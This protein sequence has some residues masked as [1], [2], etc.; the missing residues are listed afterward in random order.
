MF[1]LSISLLLFSLSPRIDGFRPTNSERN[2]VISA[3]TSILKP[4]NEMALLAKITPN[5]GESMDNYRK[6]VLNVLKEEQIDKS[7]V[8]LGGRELLDMIIRKWGVAYDIQLRKNKPFGDGS[9]NIYI[10]VMWRYFGQKSFPMD[11]REYLEHL[12]AI[13]RYITSVDKVQDFKE[14]VSD[15]RKRPNAYFGY[16]VGIALDVNP[17]TA[18]A[19][20]KDLPYE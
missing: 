5:Q 19:F 15:S 1:F 4:R 2:S 6:A 7:G 3:S 20:F 16:A 12:E 11:E 17:D 10:N 8:K 9:A 14:K 18:D 13:G